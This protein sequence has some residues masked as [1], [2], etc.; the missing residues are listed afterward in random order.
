MMKIKKKKTVQGMVIG[1]DIINI[2]EGDS[3]INK[4]ELAQC[5]NVCSQIM[6][7]PEMLKV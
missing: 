6:E 2:L 5:C 7:T 3:M 1:M 4:I